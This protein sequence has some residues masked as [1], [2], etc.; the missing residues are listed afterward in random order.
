[1]SHE[2]TGKKALVVGASGG[3]GQA[4]AHSLA[5]EGV[6]TALMRRNGDTLAGTVDACVQAGARNRSAVL[7]GTRATPSYANRAV[8]PG[9]NPSQPCLC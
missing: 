4:V 1:M 5:H 3:M 6:A 2:L 8:L 7:G 9:I